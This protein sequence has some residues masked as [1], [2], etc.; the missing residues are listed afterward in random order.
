MTGGAGNDVYVVDNVGDVVIERATEGIDTVNA[1]VHY[2]LTS[3]VERLALL[4]SS[5]LQA[6]GNELSNSISGN[7]GRNILNGDAGADVMYGLAGD[8][9]YF[10]DNAGDQVVENAGEGQDAVFS[11]AHFALSANV[12][13]HVLQGMADLQGYDNRLTNALYGNGGNNLLNGN[14]GADGM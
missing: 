12:E 11:T 4:G 2:R 6:Y 5:D 14:G 10:V 8:D 9:A 13:T 3:D 1:T 7:S